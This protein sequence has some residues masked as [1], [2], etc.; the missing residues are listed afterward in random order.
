M[1]LKKMITSLVSDSEYYRYISHPAESLQ[2][3]CEDISDE[4]HLKSSFYGTVD[5]LDQYL[6]CRVSPDIED[7]DTLLMFI[8]SS[9]ARTSNHWSFRH[10]MNVHEKKNQI[11]LNAS[12]K[13]WRK[14]DPKAFKIFSTYSEIYVCMLTFKGEIG[15]LD[16]KSRTDKATVIGNSMVAPRVRLAKDGALLTCF[17]YQDPS[18]IVIENQMTVASLETNCKGLAVGISPCE[19]EGGI[20][21]RIRAHS[22]KGD[23]GSAGD[24]V[25]I[26]LSLK[27]ASDQGNYR[28]DHIG[29]L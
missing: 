14:G 28:R 12:A 7:G 27:M 11:H 26:S 9:D 4:I 5:H 17:A 20:S 1:N 8:S 23:L 13:V 2:I 29:I 22:S 19:N 10:I 18:N 15:L 21:R 3:K 24:D 16:A 6:E 25:V